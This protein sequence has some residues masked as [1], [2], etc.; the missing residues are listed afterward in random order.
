MDTRKI[1]GLLLAGLL[2][3]ACQ[4]QNPAANNTGTGPGQTGGGNNG[5]RAFPTALPTRVVA[6]STSLA[7]DG[8]LALASPTVAAAFQTSG[9][10]KAVNVTPGQ[11]VKQGAVLATLDD[12]DL[13]TALQQAQQAL[14]L[15]QSQIAKSLAPAAPT[16]IAS[17]QAALNSAYAAYHALKAGPDPHAIQQALIS[18]DQAKNSLYSAQLSRDR[19]CG[20]KPGSSTLADVQKA[21]GNPDC[22][23]TDLNVQSSELSEQTAHQKYLDAQKPSTQDQLTQSWASVVQAQ[24]NLDALQNG[25]SA[26]QKKVYDVQL[27]QA[28]VKVDRAQRDLAQATL[29]SPCDCVVEAVGLSAGTNAAGSITLL[30][31]AQVK[32][33]TTNLSEAD[34]VKLQAGQPASIR[35]KAYPQVFTGTVG[36]VLPLASGT[37]GNLALYTALI[38]LNPA[39]VAS[40]GATLLPGMTGQAEISLQQAG[41]NK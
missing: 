36:T 7:V 13:Q 41:A 25:V 9:K 31:T 35:L 10:V 26:E 21:M 29:V 20:L 11:V 37:Q 6:A 27:Q 1:A 3:A 14:A 30:D 2:L 16:D 4:N 19:T 24:S 12:T 5:Q 8:Q 40:S 15:Q 22:K 23:I 34:V 32:F 33:E 39:D 28:Q 18:W 17:A 38:N